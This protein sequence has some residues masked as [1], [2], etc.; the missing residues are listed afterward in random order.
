MR[1]RS[2]T[3]AALPFVWSGCEVPPDFS[4]PSAF[5]QTARRILKDTAL[6]FVMLRP[7]R[8][9]C[10]SRAL[11]RQEAEIADCERYRSFYTLFEGAD[12]DTISDDEADAKSL[13][14]RIQLGLRAGEF[15]VDADGGVSKKSHHVRMAAGDPDHEG[16]SLELGSYRSVQWEPAS[17]RS[18]LSA[19]PEPKTLGR[20]RLSQIGRPW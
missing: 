16:P 5:L 18:Y 12:R 17:I 15:H 8:E 20:M 13:A 3:A 2:M 11:T 4:F 9:I 19:P 10:E 6:N 7:S 14:Q 1:M